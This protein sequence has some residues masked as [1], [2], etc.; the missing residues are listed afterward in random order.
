[1]ALDC[2]SQHTVFI[3][4]RGGITR[5]GEITNVSVIQWKRVRDD[6][7]DASLTISGA[8]CTAQGVFLASI[9]PGRHELVIFR[10]TVRVW[11]G[12]ITLLTYTSTTMR[13]EAK[14]VLFYAHRT[15]LHAGYSSAYPNIEKAIARVKRIMIAELARKEALNPP[16]NVLPYLTDHQAATDAS[17]SQITQPYQLTLLEHMTNFAQKGGMD[18]TVLGRAIHLWDTNASLGQ[19]AMVTQADFLGDV[20][21]S[22]YGAELVTF[23]ASTDGEG[24]YGFAGGNDPYYGEWEV[25]ASSYGDETTGGP[26]PTVAELTSQ[27]QRNL[28]ARNPTP[29]Q[30]RIPDNSSLNPNGIL[31]V[32]DLVPGVHIPLLATLTP[33]TLSQM[34][35]LDSVTFREDA[36]GEQ[37][38]VTLYPAPKAD[39]A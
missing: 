35:K 37:I 6:I 28:A 11:E 5:M 13:L 22:V 3:Y 14:D 10:G 12:P 16:I 18:F 20:T 26:A 24:V 39:V 17:T 38:S 36:S 30:V 29:V 1:M 32:D 7:S 27:A 4:D 31:T 33:R 9:E 25:L 8:A 23:A 21:V 19:T 15:V 2:I 34:Q